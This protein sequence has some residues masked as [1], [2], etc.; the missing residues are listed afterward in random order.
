[1]DADENK[2]RTAQLGWQNILTV[3]I[4]NLFLNSARN[5]MPSLKFALTVVSDGWQTSAA[6]QRAGTQVI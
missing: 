2:H 5:E 4:E 1:M 6:S 3:T